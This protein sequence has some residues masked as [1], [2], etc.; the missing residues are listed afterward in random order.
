M[1]DPPSPV[2]PRREGG[3]LFWVAALFLTGLLLWQL[4]GVVL[5]SFAAIVLATLLRSAAELLERFLPVSRWW[6]LAAV[7]LLIASVVAGFAAFFG[8]P[9]AK[10]AVTLVGSLPA[11]IRA[12]GDQLGIANLDVAFAERLQ[13]LAGRVGSLGEIFGYTSNLLAGLTNLILVLVAAIYLA[14]TPDLY[15][16][17]FLQL[18]PSPQRPAVA[19]VWDHSAEALGH[20]LR[21][22]LGTML[23]V[24][25]STTAGLFAI[26]MPSALALGLLAGV[27]ELIPVVGGLIAAVPALLIAVGEGESTVLW[28]LVLY[29]L[30]QQVE[31]NFITPLI[32]RNTVELP[33]ALT[34]FALVAAGVLFGPLGLFLG[35]PLAVVIFVAVKLLY[36]RDFLGEETTVPGEMMGRRKSR[37]ARRR[38]AAQSDADRTSRE[39][40]DL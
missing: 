27:A 19:S 14:A 34:L 31:G 1:A 36:L 32:N 39:R 4:S 23:I 28:V 40:I 9:V 37:S 22:M 38:A 13:E 3:G 6:A 7:S 33:P 24:G 12:L 30:V 26:G 11:R 8:E 5:L 2:N 10:D 16:N 25:A 20:W 18:V 29:V 15:R 21:G 35:A 17:G